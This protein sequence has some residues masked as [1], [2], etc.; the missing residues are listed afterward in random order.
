MLKRVGELIKIVIIFLLLSKEFREQ[1]ESSI[2]ARNS[3]HM[4]PINQKERRRSRTHWSTY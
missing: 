1:H 3:P 2:P 4:A